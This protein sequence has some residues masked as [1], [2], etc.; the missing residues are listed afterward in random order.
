MSYLH[1]KATNNIV[2]TND[3]IKHSLTKELRI[4]NS[5]GNLRCTSMTFKKDQFLENQT[6]IK[7]WIFCHSTGFLNYTCVLT[8][9]GI[10]LGLP[11]ALQNLF[12][13]Y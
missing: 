3:I 12:Q 10:L 1:D 6:K 11:N 2:F 13:N 8:N 5:L 7:N 9:S 4:D